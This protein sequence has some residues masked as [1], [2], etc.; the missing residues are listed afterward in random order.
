M[1]GSLGRERVST[2]QGG[3]GATT[4][5]VDAPSSTCSANAPVVNSAM[6]SGSREP[7]STTC[8]RANFSGLSKLITAPG[9]AAGVP[10][11]E[12]R[13]VPSTFLAAALS[14]SHEMSPANTSIET[15]NV[16]VRTK[17][18]LCVGSLCRLIE[19]Y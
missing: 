11:L 14:C 2:Q 12:Q 3:A 1:N 13:F 16:T 15:I 10:V 6:R 18:L 8:H 4:T 19:L 5:I 17:V 7:N 9:M